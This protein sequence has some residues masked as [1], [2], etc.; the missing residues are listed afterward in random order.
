MSRAENG[1]RRLSQKVCGK[2]VQVTIFAVDRGQHR[3]QKQH[4]H[5]ETKQIGRPSPHLPP[6]GRRVTMLYNTS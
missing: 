1:P 2:T 5:T 3:D 4:I 6:D